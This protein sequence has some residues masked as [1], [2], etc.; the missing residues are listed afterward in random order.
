[1]S[2]SRVHLPKDLRRPMANDLVAMTD[3]TALAAM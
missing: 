2:W 1:M 3:A